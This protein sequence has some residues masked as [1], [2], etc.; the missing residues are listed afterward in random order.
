MIQ[1][2]HQFLIPQIP[3]GYPGATAFEILGW[4]IFAA[5]LLANAS[6][7]VAFCIRPE[8]GARRARSLHL[9]A[10]FFAGLACLLVSPILL[11]LILDE[12][13]DPIALMVLLWIWHLVLM[14]IAGRRLHRIGQRDAEAG[15]RA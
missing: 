9:A 4:A 15:R 14:G 6:F 5:V 2:L 11:L 3:E 7:L 12:L 1:I 8:S 10:A 13:A